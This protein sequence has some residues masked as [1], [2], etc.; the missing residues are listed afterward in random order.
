MSHA[1]RIISIP[2]LEIERVERHQGVEVWA[3][4]C[5]RPPCMHCQHPCL[6][7]KATYL[8]TLKHTRQG[9]QILT[10]HLRVPKY[11]CRGCQRYFRHPFPGIRPRYRATESYRL[12]VFE[13][14]D[15]VS[16]SA[17]CHELMASVQPPLNA[18]T[19]TI[20]DRNPL[21]AIAAFAHEFWVLMNTFLPPKRAMPRPLLT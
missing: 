9:N 3:R 6:R 18:G 11:H 19:S 12:E 21:R 17:S 15:G 4:P 8:R 10:L 7:I 16:P 2:G 14:H 5:V 13:A 20:L 1:G